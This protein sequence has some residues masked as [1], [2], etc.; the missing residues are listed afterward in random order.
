MIQWGQ[1]FCI[2]K[3]CL[4]LSKFQWTSCFCLM[5]TRKV[6]LDRLESHH[7]D[8]SGSH[9]PSFSVWHKDE[10]NKEDV[11][12]LG[13]QNHTSSV[14]SSPLF[15]VLL[16]KSIVFKEI[17]MCPPQR[18]CSQQKQSSAVIVHWNQH[19]DELNSPWKTNLKRE[20]KSAMRWFNHFK[21]KWHNNMRHI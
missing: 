10:P 4:Q 15:K 3:N 20:L 7:I 17:L 1:T 16:P 5:I 6:D 9:C 12:I 19:T 18:K 11:F 21:D 14:H 2:W 8:S 13:P